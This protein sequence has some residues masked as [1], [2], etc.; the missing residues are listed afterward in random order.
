MS[1]DPLVPERLISPDDPLWPPGLSDLADPPQRLCMLGSLTAWDRPVI[2]IVGTRRSDT[3]GRDFTRNLAADLARQGCIV[4]SG[5]AHGIDTEAHLGALE[6]KGTSVAVLPTGL[7]RPY[8]ERNGRLFARL[9][10]QGALLSEVIGDA[11]GYASLFLERNRLVAAMARVVIVTQA[12]LASGALSTAAHAARLGRPV[13][14]VPYMPGIIRGEG[15][16]ELLARGAGICRSAGDVLS[17]AAPRPAQPRPNRSSKRARRPKKDEEFQW[18]DEDEAALLR[19]L[20]QGPLGADE[21]CEAIPLPAPRVQRAILM[22]LLSKVI[23]EVGGG[24]YMRT[25]PR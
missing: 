21:L 5:G 2:A 18:L 10:E 3:F 23:Q 4:V 22:L 8:P 12:P 16:L 20:E 14:A 13:L 25:D 11:P 9:C 15:C 19:G 24:R 6:G 17:L 7:A 1:S